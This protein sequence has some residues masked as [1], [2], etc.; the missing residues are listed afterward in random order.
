MLLVFL[1]SLIFKFLPKGTKTGGEQVAVAAVANTSNLSRVILNSYLR[2]TEY[3]YIISQRGNYSREKPGI[4]CSL[5]I[6]FFLNILKYS[7]GVSVCT[8]TRQVEHQHDNRTGRV[9][10]NNKIL[11]KKHNI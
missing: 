5:N 2:A 1:E 6:V 3:M 11:R 9:R 8:H 10:K 7:H 4:G